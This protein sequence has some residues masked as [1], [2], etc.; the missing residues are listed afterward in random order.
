MYWRFEY[1]VPFLKRLS[2]P[3]SIKVASK[4]SDGQCAKEQLAASG[5]R[6]RYCWGDYI[7]P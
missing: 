6:G 5:L 4:D 7:P 2:V 3:L 1:C